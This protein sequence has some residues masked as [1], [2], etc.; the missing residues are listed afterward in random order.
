MKDPKEMML[1]NNPF[2]SNTHPD[3]WLR[4]F[5]NI[6][7]INGEVFSAIVRIM[8]NKQQNPSVPIGIL[9]KGEAGIGKTHMIARIREYCEDTS[10]QI[11][12]SAIR[13]VI[14]YNTPLRHLFRGIITSMAHPVSESSGYTQIHSLLFSMITDYYNHDSADPDILKRFQG[15]AGKFFRYFSKYESQRGILYDRVYAWIKKEIPDIHPFFLKLLFAYGDPKQE[16]IA[17][18][19]FTG[20]IADPEDAHL[21]KV[22]FLILNL[23][24]QLKRRQEIFLYRWVF[25]SHDII[26]V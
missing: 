13:P 23:I 16:L 10:F 2:Y 9:V 22:P 1:E 4:Q 24:L 11:K 21:L 7:S 5:P 12:F 6:S 26:S 14:D 17:K 18:L 20:E 8:Q 19:R 25:S 3:P 15:D